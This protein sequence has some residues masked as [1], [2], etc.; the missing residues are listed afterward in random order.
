MVVWAGI[1]RLT[2]ASEKSIADN[3]LLIPAQVA[4]DASNEVGDEVDDEVFKCDWTSAR[5]P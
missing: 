5:L 3:K 2:H 1:C 4:L